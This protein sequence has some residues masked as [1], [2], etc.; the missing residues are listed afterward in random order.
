MPS[1]GHTVVTLL[2]AA[3]DPSGYS[4]APLELDDTKLPFTAFVSV[5]SCPQ[6]CALTCTSADI[7]VAVLPSWQAASEPAAAGTAGQLLSVSLWVPFAACTSSVT[8]EIRCSAN[9]Q[10][11]NALMVTCI[12]TR[13][14]LLQ[15]IVVLT[16]SGHVKSA[17]MP[18]SQLTVPN[19]SANASAAW[20]T[21]Q[22]VESQA[23]IM[24][25]DAASTA[26]FDVAVTGGEAIVLVAN[27]S[28]GI[29]ATSF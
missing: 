24:L 22:S 4:S 29:N 9:G 7:A 26:A 19:V 8:A 14:P 25:I 2:G 27:A 13:W 6:P 11:S 20:A 18:Q 28:V 21:I 23:A 5:Y 17:W 15:D 12:P 1:P 16:N 10:L 3:V